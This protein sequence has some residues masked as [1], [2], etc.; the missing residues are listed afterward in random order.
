MVV[1][2]ETRGKGSPGAASHAELPGDRPQKIGSAT[3][4][5]PKD[6]PSRS[7]PFTDDIVHWGA[8][9]R[10][11]GRVAC[12]ARTEGVDRV[13]EAALETTG[14]RHNTCYGAFAEY[15]ALKRD[16]FGI[17]KHVGLKTRSPCARRDRPG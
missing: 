4:W 15:Y 6:C 7:S 14:G 5:Y 17:N 13:H 9:R 12:M 3:D 2:G 10:T 1:G 11:R 8:D 16:V